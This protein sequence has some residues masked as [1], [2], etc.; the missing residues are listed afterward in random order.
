MGN[1]RLLRE[2]VEGEKQQQGEDA[3]E[4]VAGVAG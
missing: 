1:E 4:H 2:R 3:A